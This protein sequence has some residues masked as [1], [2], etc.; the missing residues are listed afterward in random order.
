MRSKIPQNCFIGFHSALAG[1]EGDRTRGPHTVH[2]SLHEPSTWQTGRWQTGGLCLL[3]RTTSPT[4]T[5]IFESQFFLNLARTQAGEP[6]LSHHHSGSSLTQEHR[7]WPVRTLTGAVFGRFEAPELK[8]CIVHSASKGPA[9]RTVVLRRDR[10]LKYQVWPKQDSYHAQRRLN[11]QWSL[12]LSGD[13]ST[14]LADIGR[15]RP[16][17]VRSWH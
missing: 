7:N 2:V 10:T 9:S 15:R 14:I 17:I 12:L 6:L 16:R 13:A 8:L 1:L 3:K 11:V 4:P 5:S